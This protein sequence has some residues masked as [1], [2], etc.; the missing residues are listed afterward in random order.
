MHRLF[1]CVDPQRKMIRVG[2]IIG[3]ENPRFRNNY[4]IVTVDAHRSDS[5]DAMICSIDRQLKLRQLEVL[6]LFHLISNVE[7]QTLFKQRAI[8][9]LFSPAFFHRG[10]GV[11]DLVDD[12]CFYTVPVSTPFY[13]FACS[14]DDE[15][16]VSTTLNTPEVHLDA[17]AADATRQ[18]SLADQRWLRLERGSLT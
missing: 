9:Y 14:I 7:A 11:S 13:S 8:D 1:R 4:T 16:T 2:V 15:M 5:E 3:M 17:F 10:S 12:M 6:P 18:F